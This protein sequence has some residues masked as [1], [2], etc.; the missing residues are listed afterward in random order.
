MVYKHCIFQLFK[1]SLETEMYHQQVMT[2]IS[3]LNHKTNYQAAVTH[4][5]L[6]YRKPYEVSNAFVRIWQMKRSMSLVLKEYRGDIPEHQQPPNC[7]IIPDQVNGQQLVDS[8][9]EE[10]DNDSS[11]TLLMDPPFGDEK[12]FDAVTYCLNDP[13]V[14]LLV[15]LLKRPTTIYTLPHYHFFYGVKNE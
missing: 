7:R 15:A 1:H 10:L 12:L 4:L 2:R 11:F 13:H 3:I 6:K 9:D 14:C 8:D 5:Q